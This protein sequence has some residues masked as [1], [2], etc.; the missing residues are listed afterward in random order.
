[1]EKF[2]TQEHTPESGPGA[3]PPSPA[4]GKNLTQEVL[5]VVIVVG[6]V[7]GVT[8]I[9]QYMPTGGEPEQ[10]TSQGM[11]TFK[12]TI[13]KFRDPQNPDPALE[14]DR[15]VDGHYDFWFQNDSGVDMELGLNS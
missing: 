5:P 2:P 1:M 15:D 4:G 12:D 14:V 9:A 11:L 7:A 3:A 10:P 6:L 8:F 13:A